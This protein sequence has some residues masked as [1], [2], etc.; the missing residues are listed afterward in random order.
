MLIMRAA[1]QTTKGEKK[2]ATYQIRQNGKMVARTL[3]DSAED[4]LTS[5]GFDFFCLEPSVERVISTNG[6]DFINYSTTYAFDMSSGA[7]AVQEV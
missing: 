4:A 5:M 7:V 2:M 6:L 1:K 3:A